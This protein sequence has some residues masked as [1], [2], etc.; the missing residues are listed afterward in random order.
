VREVLGVLQQSAEREPA[1]QRLANVIQRTVRGPEAWEALGGH[2]TLD[3]LAD[4][5]LV[6]TAPEA[7]QEK[8]VALLKT[9]LVS[10][11]NRL[12]ALGRKMADAEAAL[13]ALR[14]DLDKKRADIRALYLEAG[15]DNLD[16]SAIFEELN[17]RKHRADEM[18][19]R[20]DAMK[21]RVA[22][23][24]KQQNETP[25]PESSV[26]NALNTARGE[27]A[28]AEVES[29]AAKT[30]LDA[31]NAAHLLEL[32]DQIR[33][34]REQEGVLLGRV[35]DE[36]R[37]VD[38]LWRQVEGIPPAPTPTAPSAGPAAEPPVAPAAGGAGPAVTPMAPG[39][40]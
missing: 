12:A 28:Q 34:L 14:A 33:A 27:L 5:L 2:A 10:D 39:G 37:L 24:E 40:I 15:R 6:V 25:Q 23:L 7:T 30:Q 17:R 36:Q 9:I 38:S 19:T 35:D 13:K 31:F 22:V 26:K 32:G 21:A 11:R 3:F 18:A 20:L 8:V 16:R 4:N 1:A 29:A